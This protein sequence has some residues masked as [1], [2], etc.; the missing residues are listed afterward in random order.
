MLLPQRSRGLNRAGRR[1]W[2]SPIVVSRQRERERQGECF[3]IESHNH[4][5]TVFV[6][7][8][9]K[10]SALRNG[11]GKWNAWVLFPA[12]SGK[13][14]GT[15]VQTSNNAAPK[16]EESAE[17]HTQKTNT[18]CITLLHAGYWRLTETALVA[19]FKRI[20]APTRRAGM[21]K[22]SFRLLWDW[23]EKKW[24]CLIVKHCAQTFPCNAPGKV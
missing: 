21:G 19:H 24:V 15:T 7:W 17:A 5:V 20:F 22:Q 8:C 12:T 10:A 23:I 14:V 4:K 18:M 13:H 2:C 16:K 11:K 6:S 9:R 3:E 1:A